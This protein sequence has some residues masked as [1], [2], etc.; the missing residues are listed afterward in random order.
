MAQLD[1]FLYQGCRFAYR[2]DGSGPPLIMIQGVGACGSGVNPQIEIL[3]THFTCLSFDNRGMGK[4]MPVGRVLSAQ[5][6]ADDAAALMAHVGWD[7]AHVV[8]HSFGGLI[9]LQL[10]ISQKARV[11]SLSVLCSF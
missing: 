6:M 9:A 3:A 2:V 8:G 4:S 5:Q 11:R 10:A 7:S 1:S